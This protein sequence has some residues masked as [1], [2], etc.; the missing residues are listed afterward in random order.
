MNPLVI[1]EEEEGER[2][3]RVLSRRFADRFSRSYFQELLDQGLILLN[4]QPAKKAVKVAV[5][6]QILL[7]PP[8]STDFSLKAQPLP[9]EVLY[10]DDEVIVLN[11]AAG[12]VVHPAPGNWEGTLVNA[13]LHHCTLEEE[14]SDGL[15]PGIVHRLDKG[16]SGVMVA[17]K[18]RRA[19]EHLSR[20]F[21]CRQVHKVYVAIC[22]GNPGNATL[23]APLGRHPVRRKEMAVRETSGRAAVT[24]F[25]TLATN[26]KLSF[27]AAI[28]ETGR[29]H[30][31]RV[32][33]KAHGTPLLGDAVYGSEAANQRHGAGRPLLHSWRLTFSHPI[34]RREMTVEAP[35]PDDLLA[36]L[37]RF[38]SSPLES[39]LQVPTNLF[40]I[41]LA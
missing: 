15:R 34:T 7:P 35:L 31:I 40:T 39:L 36:F 22:L 4:G 10:E 11:K 38:S 41:P 13:L 5:G 37:R 8:P 27:I 20:S 26:E 18:T 16:T 24:H 32:H 30:Q 2:L 23:S 28:P 9:L 25:R 12:M 3:D 17:A 29:T 19:Q 6:D 21:A 33:L 14:T 1:A